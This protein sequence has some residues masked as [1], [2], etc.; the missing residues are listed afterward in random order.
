MRR[1]QTR[2]SGLPPGPRCVD[3][4]VS[5]CEGDV[6]VDLWL[7]VERVLWNEM[8]GRPPNPPHYLLVCNVRPGSAHYPQAI[9]DAKDG[10]VLYCDDGIRD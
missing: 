10:E 4:L 5:C 6:G 9:I 8:A 7:Q 1:R 2:S 3:S